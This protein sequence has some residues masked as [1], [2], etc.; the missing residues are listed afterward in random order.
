VLYESLQVEG[1]LTGQE[2]SKPSQPESNVWLVFFHFNC[3]GL[4]WGGGHGFQ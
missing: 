2:S 1:G 4:Q 3:F